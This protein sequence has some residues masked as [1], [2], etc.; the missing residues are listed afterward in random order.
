MEAIEAHDLQLGQAAMQQLS[1]IPGIRVYGPPDAH[2]PV[3]SFNLE[4]IHP[5]DL[6]TFLDQ[7]RVAVRSGH[8]CCQLVMKRLNVAATARAS[9]YLYNDEKD[10]RRL[11]AALNQAKDY[12]KKW[13]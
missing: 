9:F 11:A 7:E 10:V 6:A 13:L 2:G 8:H 3:V 4:N 5:H 12:F 1:A